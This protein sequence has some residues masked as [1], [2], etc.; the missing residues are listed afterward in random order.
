MKK[1]KLEKGITLIALI[2]TIIVLLIL[3]VVTIGAVQ[4]SKIISHA[5]KAKNDYTTPQEKEQK[6]LALGEWQIQK[7]IGG[8]NFKEIV[9][10]ALEDTATVSGNEDGPLTITMKKTGNQYIITT[11][12]E[13]V[14]GMKSITLS[15]R[16][17]TIVKGKTKTITASV[18]GGLKPENITYSSSDENVATVSSEGLI[19]TLTTG[20]TTI[21]AKCNEYSTTCKVTVREANDLDYYILGP[22][23]EGRIITDIMNMET[24]KF[25]DD[26][27]TEGIDETQTIGAEFISVAVESD[28]LIIYF[29]SQ[30]IV[31]KFIVN[32]DLGTTD[33]DYGVVQLYI[34]EE[35]SRVG[36]TVRYDNKLWR[37]LYDDDING[38]QMV[39]EESLKYNGEDFL[40]GATDS[41]VSNWNELI[42]VA[43]LNKDGVLNNLE[44]NVYSYNNAITTLNTAC[45]N[46]VTPSSNILDVRCVGSNPINKNA[47]NTT[48]YTSENLAKWPINNETYP[49]G[50]GN[51]IGKSEDFN[52]VSDFERMVV[53]EINKG[54]YWMASRAIEEDQYWKEVYM[55]IKWGSEEGFAKNEY[56]IY[57]IGDDVVYGGN[58]GGGPGLRPVI[59]LKSDI[60]FSG[61]GTEADPYTF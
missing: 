59:T 10:T 29:K 8:K 58:Y 32:L 57:G 27:T 39:S 12:G 52:Y 30:E 37:I 18:T 3:A 36:K 26:T 60:Q 61:L 56:W 35:E 20:T 23:L 5:Q 33:A 50:I 34:A 17:L 55:Y 48:L 47:E 28:G 43:D 46:I 25:I 4:K 24:F 16:T 44:K 45:E 2:I 21:T 31:Y 14:L 42:D 6:G 51:G 15:D 11:D 22:E 53:L 49:A 41:L 54:D 13:V 38:L 40:L 1:T 9:E 7:V 19:T